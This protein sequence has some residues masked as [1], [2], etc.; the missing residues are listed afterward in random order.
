MTF[1]FHWEGAFALT[2]NPRLPASSWILVPSHS[3]KN[4]HSM[5]SEAADVEVRNP[6]DLLG[7]EINHG[8]RGCP[9]HNTKILLP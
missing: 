7:P 6:F 2:M 8:E 9:A 1:L 3:D 4:L 5:A